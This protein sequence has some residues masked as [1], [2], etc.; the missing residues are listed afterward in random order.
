MPGGPSATLLRQGG[1]FV[2]EKAFIGLKKYF[3]INLLIVI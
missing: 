2:P 1:F 3:K